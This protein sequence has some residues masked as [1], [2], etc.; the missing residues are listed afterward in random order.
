MGGMGG[1]MGFMGVVSQ[2]LAGDIDEGHGAPLAPAALSSN[3][4]ICIRAS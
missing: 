1:V 2:R 4:G 3:E